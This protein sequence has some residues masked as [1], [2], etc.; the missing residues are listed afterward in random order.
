M[1]DN[2]APEGQLFSRVYLRRNEPLRDSQRFRTRL[3]GYFLDNFW[4]LRRDF[5]KAVKR[6]LGVTVPVFAVTT[7][8]YEWNIPAFFASAELRDILDSISLTIAI[9]RMKHQNQRIQPYLTF[10]QRALHEENMGY[11]LDPQGGV[12]YIVDDEFERNRISALACL[13][14]PKFSAVASSMEGAFAKMDAEPF[15]TKGSVR[16]MFEAVETLTK[17]ISNSSQDLTE[18]FVKQTLKPLAQSIYQKFDAS[19]ISVADLLLEGMCHWVNAGHKYRHGQKT[20]E[21]I[22]PPLEITILFLSG[23]AG[24]IRWLTELDR[25]ASQAKS[26]TT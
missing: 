15:D 22:A 17:L 8:S 23:G 24:Y 20:A 9:L 2:Q 3:T 13:N 14:D 19:A 4:D 10:V 12:H 26:Q 11:R 21:P 18:R 6:E 16:D 5:I 1:T 25:I 7:Q